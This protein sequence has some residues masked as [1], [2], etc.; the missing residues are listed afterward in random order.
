MMQLSNLDSKEEED[1]KEEAMF[2][3]EQTYSFENLKKEGGQK[4][5]GQKAEGQT[6]VLGQMSKM[7]L[8]LLVTLLTKL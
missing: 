4:A 6:E 1:P 8:T 3:I 2:D 5:E 7:N